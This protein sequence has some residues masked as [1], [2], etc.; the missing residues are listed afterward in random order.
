M[1]Q[2]FIV[3]QLAAGS[4]LPAALC[5]SLQQVVHQLPHQCS[6]SCNTVQQAVHYLLHWCG[7]SA[8]LCAAMCYIVPLLRIYLAALSVLE[9]EYVCVL[10]IL[11]IYIPLLLLIY[12][13]YSC[14][15]LL[16][17]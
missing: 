3:L 11:L 6:P 14:R 13:C 10:I 5:C 15:F 4:A 2:A 9:L 17:G 8:A 7:S 16:L 12:I 1:L